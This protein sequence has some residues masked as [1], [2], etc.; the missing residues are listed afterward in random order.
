MSNNPRIAY[1]GMTHLGICSSIAAASKSFPTVGFSADRELVAALAAGRLPIVEPELDELLKASRANIGFSS[2]P[3][4]LA[5]CDVV[6]VAPDIPT[7]AAGGSDLTPIDA[8]L[9]LAFEHVRSDAVIVVLS[10]VPPGFTRSRRRS[11]PALFYQVETLIFGRA[12]ERATRPERFIVGCADSAEPLP[13]AF[14]SFLGAFGCP[15]LAMRYES[16]ELAK[17][18]INCCLV[19]SVATANTLAEICERIGADWTEIVPALRL[20]RRI[21]AYS[22]LNP[23]LGLAGGNLERDL[24]TVVALGDSHGTEVGVVRAWQANSR[25]RRDW[26]LRTLHDA[27]LSGK[28][29]IKLALLGLA[30]K[31]NTHSTKNSPA[32]AL[33]GALPPIAVTAYDPVVAPQRAWHPAL[34]AAPDALA[35][36]K[37]ADALVIMTPWPEFKSLQPRDIASQL[38]G[39]IVIDPFACLSRAACKAAGLAHF[40][41]GAPF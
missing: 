16:A 17:I 7:D 20:D 37:G 23:G 38:R 36:C 8:L 39:K 25:Y 27:V 21:G 13:L 28:A 19:A 4:D 11:G 14:A 6:Y 31:E 34:A 1:V 40:V 26:T 15:V 10:Q 5:A 2:E 32:L 33:L 3:N 41:L 35:A 30:Y 22:Y 24:A 9:D 12:V 18:A 29:D